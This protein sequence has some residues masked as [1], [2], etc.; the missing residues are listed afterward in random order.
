MV[1]DDGEDLVR[2]VFPHSPSE[3]I[4][5][6]G[7]ISRISLAELADDVG[8]ERR[9]LAQV[10]TIR[11]T[12]AAAVELHDHVDG[13]AG[14]SLLHLLDVAQTK[15]VEVVVAGDP[16]Q[17]GPLLRCLGLAHDA[18][19]GKLGFLYC[20]PPLAPQGAAQ[21]V[22]ARERATSSLAYGRRSN[23]CGPEFYSPACP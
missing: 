13:V 8:G 23:H 5:R 21:S 4:N 20:V 7:R 9:S 2:G 19:L 1:P 10:I 17:H 18:F 11:L 15:A 6:D 22:I 16:R 12:V 14:A 3:E